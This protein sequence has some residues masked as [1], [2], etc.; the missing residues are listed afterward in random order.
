[1]K[2]S[3]E[4]RPSQ[5]PRPRVMRGDG[6]P[7]RRSVHRGTAGRCIELRKH[8][9]VVADLVLTG[10]RQQQRRASKA[11]PAL[12]SRSLRPR[13]RLETFL[14]EAERP[15]T[16]SLAPMAGDRSAKASVLL[17]VLE[18]D[19]KERAVVIPDLPRTSQIINPGSK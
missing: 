13:A 4:V 5:S 19:T 17:A 7:A 6:Q 11:S 18:R 16:T 8:L 3:Y 1:M 10:G 14:T 12:S 9:F 15:R 2:E